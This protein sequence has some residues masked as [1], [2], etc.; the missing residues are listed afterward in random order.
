M[1]G[2][3][4]FLSLLLT[5]L[6]LE[7]G[8]LI[9]QGNELEVELERTRD[10]LHATQEELA[11]IES[12]VPEVGLSAETFQLVSTA[13]ER[14]TIGAGP[15]F[16][17]FFSTSCPACAEDAPLWSELHEEY[18]EAGVEFVAVCVKSPDVS[19]QAF[20]QEWGVEFPVV[21][22]EDPRLAL[23]YR[24]NYFPKRMLIDAEGKVAWSDPVEGALGEEGAAEMR[25]A[26]DR[27]LSS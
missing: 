1:K 20:A 6:S 17:V 12:R 26:L 21:Q 13:G 18:A 3:T 11:K 10:S 25:D 4:V 19:A 5:G 24:A 27:L 15:S 8:F 22:T 9:K 14:I 23:A 7:V 16:L 2:N